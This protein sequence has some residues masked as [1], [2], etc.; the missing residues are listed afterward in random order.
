MIHL[1]LSKEHLDELH[2]QATENPCVRFRKKCWVV[3][4]KGNGYT[5]LEIAR[6]VRV[7][8]DSITE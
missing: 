2:K 4:L 7:T 1:E 3:Y 6:V 8:E 5:H